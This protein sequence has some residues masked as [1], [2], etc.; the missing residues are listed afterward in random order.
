LEPRSQAI[1]LGFIGLV[2]AV[3]SHFSLMALIP[4]AILIAAFDTG[5]PAI[6]GVGVPQSLV[7]M[8]E[9]LILFFVAVGEYLLRYRVGVES[10][11]RMTVATPNVNETP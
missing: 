9:G 3:L 1:G 8:L 10:A 2:I 7:L 6:Q 5:G 11:R 4:V